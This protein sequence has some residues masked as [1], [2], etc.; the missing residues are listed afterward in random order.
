MSDA[1]EALEAIFVSSLAPTP[2]LHQV[3]P[4]DSKWDKHKSFA[5]EVSRLYASVDYQSLADKICFCADFLSFQLTV[6][7]GLKLR[8]ARFCRNRHCPICQWRRSMRWKRRA[9]QGLPRVIEEFPKHRWIFLTFTIRNCPVEELRSSI[10]KMNDAF[11]LMTKRVAWPGKGWI[12]SLEVTRS[13][14]GEAHPHFHIL[15]LVNPSYFSGKSYLSQDKWIDFWQDCL[16][17]EYRP[18]IRVRAIKAENPSAIIPE[19][20]KYQTKESNLVADADWLM[21]LTQQ[22]HKVRAISV[23]GVLRKY[24]KEMEKE[25]EDLIGTDENDTEAVSDALLYFS[26]KRSDSKYKLED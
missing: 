19:V 21:K 2:Y 9:Y 4:Q 25:P 5:D 6:L 8:A 16:N 15:V 10:E 7:G 12:K 24:F 20:L 11:A 14:I 23:G 3:S 26:W 13:E 22:M 1:D 17:V 18:S